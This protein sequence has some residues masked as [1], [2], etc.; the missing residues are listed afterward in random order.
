MMNELI[1]KSEEE[2]Q[3]ELKER[4]AS[5]KPGQSRDGK[6]VSA[7][8]KFVYKGINYL[9][10]VLKYYNHTNKFTTMCSSRISDSHVVVEYPDETKPILDLIANEFESEFL[11]HDTL[12]SWNDNQ[13]TEEQIEVCHKWAKGDIDNLLGGEISKRVDEGIKRLQDIKNKLDG[14]VKKWHI[15]QKKKK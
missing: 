1:W 13:T 4:I 15:T 11:Y 8:G 10:M 5:W 9:I 2:M 12:H 3:K 7:E 6:I 14:G